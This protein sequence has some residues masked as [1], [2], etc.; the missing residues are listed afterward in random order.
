MAK[1]FL[2]VPS[3]SR[4]I[5]RVTEIVAVLS[6]YGLADWLARLD[7]RFVEQ[8]ARRTPLATPITSSHEARIRLAFTDLG[9]TFI[10]LGQMLSTRRDLIG[11]ALANE[12]CQL[13][14]NVPADPF[15][16]TRAT[17]ETELGQPIG[18]LFAT[19]DETAFASA[20][21]GQCHRATLADGRRVV[22]KVQHPGI[23]A[24]IEVDLAILAGLAS[25]AEQYITDLQ[26][27]QPMAVVAE[28]RRTILRELDFR[29][30]LRHL[31]LFTQNFANDPHLRFPA[32][33]PDRSSGRVLTMDELVGIP[34]TQFAT[35]GQPGV[36]PDELARR[37][38]D[39]FLN[40]IFRDGFYHADPHPG[41]I[42]VLPGGVIGLLDVGMVGRVDDR[43]RS[44]IGRA[45][46]AVISNDP[47][48][49]TEL[50]VRVG[51]V[52][53]EFDA[54][55]LETDVAEQLSFYYG[56]PLDQFELGTALD[57]LTDAI[58][59]YRVVLP[60]SFALLLKVLV[61]LEG[62]A[63]LVSPRFNLTESIKP[64]RKSIALRAYSP[65]RLLRR[66]WIALQEWDEVIE[67]LPRQL[68]D[69]L[70]A[71]HRQDFRVKLEHFHLEP[72]V[73]RLVFGVMTS[74]L[75]VGSS[76]MWAY[77]APPLIYGA[78]VFGILGC[79]FSVVLGYRLFRAIQQSGRLEDRPRLS[80]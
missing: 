34:L 8:V 42:L 55:D 51:R 72:S 17:I 12:L 22:V 64:F 40:M 6:K 80:K 44:Q 38:A 7:S 56:M 74:A 36:N 31:Q 16:A 66:T 18:Q 77:A 13:Q 21:I 2:A 41:N 52:S 59:R 50:I 14:S 47:R 29:R 26:P 23:A 62:T 19:F 10:K 30:E 35:T 60:S 5:G 49:L 76:M 20:S 43:M 58:R 65:R 73:N 1:S 28:F 69:L 78:S 79:S 11:T 61:M 39:V 70:S 32:P 4:H 46:S 53:P 71:A 75:F 48:T 24:T 45:L 15:S 67:A 25:L 57:E 37:G 27:Y 9:T 33:V 63:R 54:S 3:L 68:R